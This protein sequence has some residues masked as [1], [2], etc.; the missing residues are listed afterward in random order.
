MNT[1][2]PL[3]IVVRK[4]RTSSLGVL[5]FAVACLLSAPLEAQWTWAGLNRYTNQT[6]VRDVKADTEVF[7]SARGSLRVEIETQTRL[8]GFLEHAHHLQLHDFSTSGN[9]H[10]RY[11]LELGGVTVATKDIRTPGRV[12]APY[13]TRRLYPQNLQRSYLTT[14]GVFR[15]A[16]NLVAGGIMNADYKL[17]YSKFV[18]DGSF[19][20]SLVGEM[21]LASGFG[22]IDARIAFGRCGFFGKVDNVLIFSGGGLRFRHGDSTF[23][24]RFAQSFYLGTQPS[25]RTI[26]DVKVP[27]TIIDPYLV[28]ARL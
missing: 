28:V 5:G 8:Y 3:P 25:W 1:I 4:P 20:T 24:L 22:L 11:T 17:N 15:V 16:A 21:N 6:S 23:R 10:V 26:Y 19:D 18:P 2:N 7:A 13:V 12:L 9:P 27:Y 14:A